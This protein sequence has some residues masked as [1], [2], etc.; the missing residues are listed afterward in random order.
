MH[1]ALYS[2]ISRCSTESYIYIN[3]ST[4]HSTAEDAHSYEQASCKR[5]ATLIISLV[6]PIRIGHGNRYTVVPRLMSFFWTTKFAANSVVQNIKLPPKKQHPDPTESEVNADYSLGSDGL[7]FFG[8]TRTK[9]IIFIFRLKNIQ[10]FFG[11]GALSSPAESVRFIIHSSERADVQME[12]ANKLDDAIDVSSCTT[13]VDD[14]MVKWKT[15]KAI[16]LRKSF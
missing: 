4:K 16:R 1:K 14:I 9:A 6:N 2:T 11:V 12:S 5:K 15:K 7:L 13:L 10:L 8:N 3:E